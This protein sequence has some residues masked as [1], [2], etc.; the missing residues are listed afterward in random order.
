MKRFSLFVFFLGI[1][2]ISLF[3]KTINDAEIIHPES[4]VYIKMKALQMNE[5]L[6]FF[7][8]NTPIS[9]GEM[10]L[11]LRKIDYANLSDEGKRIYDNVYLYLYEDKNMLPVD[12]VKTSINLKVNPELY[13]KSNDEIPW[14]NSYFFKDN[15]MTFPITLGFSNYFAGQSDLFFGKNYISMHKND[16][17]TNIPLKVKDFEFF[18][19]TYAFA[20]FGQTFDNWGYNFHVGKQGKT[21]GDTISGSILYN[22]TFESDY[23]SELNLYSDVMKITTDV[24]QISSNR[25]DNIQNDNIDRYLYSHQI[26]IR[27]FK[28]AKVTF[29]EASLIANPFQLRFLNPFISMHQYGGWTD[30]STPDSEGPYKTNYDVYKETNF[31]AYFASLFEYIPVQNVRLYGIYNQVEM[32]LPW[33]RAQNRGKYYPNSIGLQLGG[34]YNLFLQN[35]QMINFGGEFVY[36]SPY[37]Y[38]K[39]VPSSSLYKY[40]VDMQTKEKVYS[41]IGTPFGPDCIAGQLKVVYTQ[42]KKLNLEIDYVLSIKGMNDFSTFEEVYDGVYSYYPSVIWY[43][44]KNKDFEKSYDDLYDDVINLLPTGI[45]VITNQICLQGTYSLMENLNLSGKIAY[46]YI[47][48]NNHIEN[49]TDSGFE[50]SLA[51]TYSLFN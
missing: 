43:L 38:M 23:Y 19:P 50:L 42:N 27:L 30:Y 15:F 7:T 46:T 49:K 32:Q 44:I 24:V 48:N 36:T 3:A 39:Q 8:Q 31:C 45:P 4:D 37:M 33:E 51:V 41:W 14:T 17:F 6:F 16:N 21:I 2:S 12:Y 11:Y 26:D 13:Y 18:F 5:Q 35:N 9:T 29:F 10:K 34:E 40:R 20:S 1:F 22:K 47:I 28:K 25:M